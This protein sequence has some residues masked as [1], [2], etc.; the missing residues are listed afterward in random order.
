MDRAKEKCH[1][2]ATAS[3]IASAS[4]RPVEVAGVAEEAARGAGAEELKYEEAS[5]KQ[6]L[7]EMLARV[8]PSI[9]SFLAN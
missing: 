7:E 5:P 8:S 3:S 6:I 2:F 9:Y 4:P 1:R